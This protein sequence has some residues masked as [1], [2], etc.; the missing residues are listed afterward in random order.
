M[1]KRHEKKAI[2]KYVLGRGLTNREKRALRSK[3]PSLNFDEHCMRTLA[4]SIDRGRE[5]FVQLACSCRLAAASFDEL[6]DALSELS[7][8]LLDWGLQVPLYGRV[9]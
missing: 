5:G 9:F 8:E 1:N 2:K 4:M 3:L 6:R 7:S